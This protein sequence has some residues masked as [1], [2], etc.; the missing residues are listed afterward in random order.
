MRR[1]I[2]LFMVDGM[3]YIRGESYAIASP[4]HI[5]ATMHYAFDT[6]AVH[7]P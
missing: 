7:M 2:Y 6:C 3:Q 5:H 4:Q 1:H